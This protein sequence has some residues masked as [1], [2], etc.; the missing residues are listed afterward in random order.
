MTEFAQEEGGDVGFRTFGTEVAKEEQTSVDQGGETEITP[1]SFDSMEVGDLESLIQQEGL[2]IDPKGMT[3]DQLRE[4]VAEALGFEVVEEEEGDAKGRKEG[5]EKRL[6]YKGI[7][8]KV[9][10]EFEKEYGS[11]L[12]RLE[13]L[14]NKARIVDLIE[15]NPEYYITKMAEHFGVGLGESGKG[16]EFEPPDLEP[17]EDETMGQFLKRRDAALIKAYEE[18]Q[19]KQTKATRRGPG[20]EQ[21]NQTR[22]RE[23][24]DYLET[25]HPD[26]ALY[27]DEMQEVLRISPELAFKPWELYKEAKNAKLAKRSASSAKKIIQRKGESRTGERSTKPQNLAKPRGALSF[28]EAWNRAKEQAK[29]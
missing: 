10:R 8:A 22:T 11:K 21:G 6:D 1:E 9:R 17:K 25:N 5:E 2:D 13:G 29:G 23:I 7:E 12:K 4:A 16:G 18:H 28:S 24:M 19:K 20:P 3:K 27:A 14:E 15:Q 26:F